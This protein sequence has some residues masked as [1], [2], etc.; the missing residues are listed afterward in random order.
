[1]KHRLGLERAIETGTF[2][3]DG[4][5]T[6]AHVFPEVVSIE[7]SPSCYARAEE[8]LGNVRNIDLLL[9]DSRSLM[10]G[11]I[12]PDTPTLYFLDGHW[13]DGL[14]SGGADDQCPLIV[15]ISALAGGHDKD[16]IIIDDARYFVA[17]PPPPYKAGDWPSF[18]DVIDALRAAHPSHHVTILGD[19]ILSVPAEARGIVDEYWQH[20]DEG[21]L[22]RTRRKVLGRLW[23]PWSPTRIAARRLRHRLTDRLPAP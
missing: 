20:H 13:S 23:L 17:A 21:R 22:M 16:C 4:A 14:T 5:L 1:L 11:L 12:R 10:P 9:G 2:E 3:G 19:Q 6:L 18:V 7:V 15:E 8:R